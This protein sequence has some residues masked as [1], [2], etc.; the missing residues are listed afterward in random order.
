MGQGRQVEIQKKLITEKRTEVEY[1]R[2]NLVCWIEE[3]ARCFHIQAAYI[4]DLYHLEELSFP[5]K[6]SEE[7]GHP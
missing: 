2:V 6:R 3:K 5:R 1:I 7:E 4:K